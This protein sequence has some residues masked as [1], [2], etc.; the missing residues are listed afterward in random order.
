MKKILIYTALG[1]SLGACSRGNNESQA[2]LQKPLEFESISLQRIACYGVCPVYSVEI[3]ANGQVT[4][5]GEEFVKIKGKRQSSI[6]QADVELV[7]AAVRHVNFAEMNEAYVDPK[8]GCMDIPRD[9]PSLSISIVKKGKP[10]TVSFYTG[11]HGPTVPVERLEWLA[12][13]ID[14]MARTASLVEE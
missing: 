13:T 11:C 10:K 12:R 7:S 1:L 8:D 4:F 2:A 14:I 3:Q 9:H 5:L 6:P